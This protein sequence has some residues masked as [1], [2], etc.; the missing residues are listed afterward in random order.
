[1]QTGRIKHTWS[2]YIVVIVESTYTSDYVVRD[3][4]HERPIAH[5]LTHAGAANVCG[6]LNAMYGKV[7]PCPSCGKDR[8]GMDPANKSFH[9]VAC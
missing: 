4:F 8:Y 1:M 6:A 5:C 7:D 9:P 2:R 3:T